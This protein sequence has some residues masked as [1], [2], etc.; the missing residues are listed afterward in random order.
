[1]ANIRQYIGARYV[2]KI[3]ENSQDPSSAEWEA[4]VTYEPLT[5]VTYL[6]STYASKKDVPGS[7]GNPAANPQY[8][9]VT[10]AYNG[11]IA[12]LQQQIDTLNNTTIPGI[13]GQIDTINNVDLP[14]IN[15][16]I[17]DL[18][19]DVENLTALTNKRIVIITDSYGNS[20]GGDPF[21][22]P[23]QTYLGLSNTDYFAYA[24]GSLGFNQAGLLGH[25]AEQLLTLHASDITDHDTITHVIFVI[26]GNDIENQTGLEAAMSSC[27]SYAKATYSNAKIV[28]AYSYNQL[29]KVPSYEVKYYQC[30]QNYI[31]YVNKLGA[32]WVNN[33]PYIMH[34]ADNFY[35]DGVHP[36]AAG[37]DALALGLVAYFKNGQSDVKYIK[38]CT[39]SSVNGT[40]TTTF[41][42]MIDNECAS[43]CGTVRVEAVTLSTGVNNIKVGS[44]T[45]P[46]FTG[47]GLE[48]YIP[49]RAMTNS[50][51]VIP[52]MI[53]IF[54]GDVYLSCVSSASDTIN[55]GTNIPTGTSVQTLNI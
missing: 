45:S 54:E 15:S 6:N 33:Y 2:F 24:E 41:R 21:T 40:Y 46:L 3:Y 44:I 31:K 29:A 7:V 42:L 11:Q 5:I 10:G 16:A 22:V 19:S 55:A 49:S 38:E 13:Q 47:T 12:T 23:L 52:V 17:Q 9:I 1:M 37:S 20:H 36:N 39:Y 51:A 8:W 28:V 34:N 53:Y 27:F 4:N 26:G 35:T 43:V 18:E 30:I 14:N 25:N 48:M 50:G 32:E